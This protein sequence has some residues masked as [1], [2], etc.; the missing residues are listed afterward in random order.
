MLDYRCYKKEDKRRAGAP[1][2]APDEESETVF[3]E[4][5]SVLCKACGH[6]VTSS[7]YAVEVEG[8]H[9][10]TFFNPAGILFEIGCFEAAPGTEVW[11]VPTTEFAWFKGFAWRFCN[12][13]G[14]HNH[15]GWQFLSG[16]SSF[17]GLVLN[18]LTEEV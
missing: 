1:E 18:R 4:E 2:Q 6:K 15:I 7:N 3:E 11:G 14:C 5:R 17:Y 9:R 16:E 10:H 8:K 12:C 13:A